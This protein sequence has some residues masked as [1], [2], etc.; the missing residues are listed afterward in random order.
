MPWTADEPA[1]FLAGRSLVRGGAW[2]TPIHR[3]QGP[4]PLLANQLFTAGMEGLGPEQTEPA[5]VRA[6]LGM[7]PFALLL[8]LVVRAWARER[9]EERRVGKESRYRWSP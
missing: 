4:L 8:L 3:T 6:R 5:R 9:S 7:L 2:E 1:L